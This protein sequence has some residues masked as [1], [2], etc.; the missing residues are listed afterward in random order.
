MKMKSVVD[1]MNQPFGK[2]VTHCNECDVRVHQRMY[3][4]GEVEFCKCQTTL[5]ANF[6]PQKWYWKER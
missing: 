6:D 4:T 5:D 3:E 1:F 2:I